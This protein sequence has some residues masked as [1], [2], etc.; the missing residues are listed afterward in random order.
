MKKSNL[1]FLFLVLC[2]AALAMQAF[3]SD[4][5]GDVRGPQG[6]IAGVQIVVTDQTGK[7]VAQTLTDESGRYC[8]SGLVRGS[9]KST[10]KAPT[11]SGFKSGAV[12]IDLGEQGA[13]GNWLVSSGHVASAL[14]KS[15]GSCWAFGRLPLWVPL[16][17]TEAGLGIGAASAAGAASQSGPLPVVSGSR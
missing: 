7:V 4:I 9:Y 12:S 11:G 15:A 3:C 1:S 2:L 13:T 5:T 10:V 14:M 8:I 16:G 17:M 6:P